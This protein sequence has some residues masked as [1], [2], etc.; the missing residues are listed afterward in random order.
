MIQIN[1]FL[2]EAAISQWGTRTK[3]H[4]VR[5]YLSLVGLG[6]SRDNEAWCSAFMVWTFAQITGTPDPAGR[7]TA[8][9]WLKA[10]PEGLI[11]TTIPSDQA[12]AGDV[13][14]MW[15][16][17]PNS[18]KGHVGLF[19]KST[20]H[21]VWLLGGNQG[22]RVCIRRYKRNRVLMVRRFCMETSK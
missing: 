1:S 5:R 6:R 7:A 9:S 13:W 18:W 16:G 20:K 17:A 10:E 14:V 8:R 22:E 21:H 12:E 4:R 2:L 3:S 11:S 15:R 19:I